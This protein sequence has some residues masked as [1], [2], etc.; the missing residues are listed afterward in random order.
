MPYKYNESRR[1]H[2]KKPTYR[3][4][5]YAEYNQSLRER[6]RIDIW[7]SDDIIENW[8]TEQRT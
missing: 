8:Q 4:T 1:H 3:Q 5:N 7:L 6:G 2:F